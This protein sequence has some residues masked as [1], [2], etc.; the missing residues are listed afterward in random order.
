MA[1]TTLTFMVPKRQILTK[2]DLE[3]FRESDAYNDYVGFTERLNNSV[4]GLSLSTECF[5]SPTLSKMLELLNKANTYCEEIPPVQNEKSRFGNPAFKVFYSRIA[6]NAEELHEIFS[7]P[8]EA[9]KEVSRYF[10]ESWGDQ[11][12]IDYGT[13]H[14][15]NFIAWLL[16]FEKLGLIGPDDYTSI[17]LRVFQKYIDVMRNLQ[18]KYWLEPAGSHGVWGLD[19]YHFLPF[20]FGSAQ[21]IGHKYIKPKSIHDKDVVDEFSKEYMYLACIK[22]INSVKTASLRWNSPML[23]D[24]S[25]VKEWKKVNE[26]M[27]KMYKGEV[28][29]KLP[30]MQHFMFG[31]L[32]YFEGS[33]S[34][35]K[36][37]DLECDDNHVHAFGQEFPDCCGIKVPSAIGASQ[38]NMGEG[39]FRRLPFD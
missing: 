32:I 34:E 9:V 10:M 20:M 39:T 23:D 27:I 37:Q 29:G 26:G 24:I 31:S 6:N 38:I 8:P 22:F 17:V 14:E 18:F 4:K 25:G 28:L 35:L 21:L 33:S 15:A 12:R 30:I 36:E 11:K 1:A 13:G 2:D 19:D 16:C 7:L 5:I 3:K